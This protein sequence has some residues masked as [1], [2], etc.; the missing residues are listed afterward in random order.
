MQEA[1]NNAEAA[2]RAKT[3]FL[4]NMS[5]EV[6]TP[7]NSIL[8]YAQLLLRGCENVKDPRPKLQS[9]IDSGTHLLGMM[10]ELLDLARVESGKLA[11]N[12][13]PLNL[14]S[15]LQ[16]LVREFEIRAR[17]SGLKFEFSVERALPQWIETDPLR[18][19]QIVYNLV[20]N[21]F[22]FTHAGSVSLQVSQCAEIYW[23]PRLRLRRLRRDRFRLR[24]QRRDRVR[25]GQALGRDPELNFE[26]I[27]S[28]F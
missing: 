12:P 25:L 5:H 10:N 22:K 11:I 3:A 13:E 18:L 4:A 20:G 21:A 1:K 23:R 26:I 9:I 19:R 16:S 15:F 8:G 28:R 24:R 7:L 17:Q 2:N 6:R 14:P 27:T